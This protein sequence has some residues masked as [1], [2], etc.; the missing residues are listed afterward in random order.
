MH[1]WKYCTIAFVDVNLHEYMYRQESMYI[2]L[3]SHFSQ[4]K[5]ENVSRL[6]K[7]GFLNH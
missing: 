6:S 3:F 4:N 5:L 1:R 7:L 2:D